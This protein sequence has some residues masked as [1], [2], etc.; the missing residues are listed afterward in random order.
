MG[1]VNCPQCERRLKAPD[2]G[3]SES[4][5]C[6]ACNHVFR[7]PNLSAPAGK[8]PGA[9][10]RDIPD[11]GEAHGSDTVR[12]G[13]GSGFLELTRESDDTSLGDVLYTAQKDA[14]SCAPAVAKQTHEQQRPTA[15]ALQAA[16]RLAEA[17]LEELGRARKNAL[18]AWLTA[19]ALAIAAFA[20]LYWAMS[21]SNALDLAKAELKSRHETLTRTENHLKDQRALASRLL[22]ELAA[23]R[24][25]RRDLQVENSELQQELAATSGALA[26]KKA[27]VKV[28]SASLQSAK[29]RIDRLT[30]EIER[31][32]PIIKPTARPSGRAAPPRR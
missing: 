20:M 27:D 18:L 11:N 25:E 4:L 7:I 6:P 1:L 30:E 12:F 19:G 29:G 17:R 23:I 31:A 2:G 9:D 26:D 32:R 8:G 14:A 21:R 5:R 24:A 15:P 28:L 22:D 3:G 13:A 10:E 16:N